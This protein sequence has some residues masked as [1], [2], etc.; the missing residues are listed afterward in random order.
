M[1][2]MTEDELRA[3]TD[4]EIADATSFSEALATKR[5][6]NLSYFMGLAEGDLAPPEIE[7]RSSVVD[8]T[9]RNT[10]LGMEGPLIKTFC[11]TENVVEFS[12]TTEDDEEKAKQVT[13]YLNYLLRKKN[14]GYSIVTTWIRDALL[15]KYGFVK[16][17]W[18]DSPVETKEEYRGQTD[19]QLTI[20][21]DDDEIEVIN[22][23]S[24]ED[25]EAAEDK[26]KQLQQMEAQ[27]QQMFEQAQQAIQQN[28]SAAQ[29][30]GQQ[31]V[32]ARQQYEAFVAQPIPLLYDITVRRKKE[33]GRLCVENVPPEEMLVPRNAKSL[34]SVR[35][36]G[37]KVRRT[38]NQLKAAKYDNVKD[39][40][41]GA[42]GHD[43]DTDEAAHRHY[44]NGA[45]PNERN[46]VEPVDQGA[47]EVWITVCYVMCDYDGNGID[48]WRQV[49]RCGKTILRNVEVDDHEFVGWCPIPMP[50]QMIGLC[51]ADLAMP[52]QKAKTFLKRGLHD[53]VH[54]Q[55]NGRNYALEG[56]VN[57]DDLLD[58][59][60]GGVVR[61][62]ELGAVGRLDQ[63][64][65]D[66]TGAMTLLEAEE[67]DG[68]EST[69]WT[70]QSQ[71]GNGQPLDQT[72]TAAN[73][74]TNR[75]DARTE[76][77]AR[78]FAETGYP[79][80]FY[81]M[82]K[83]VCQHQKKADRVKLNGKWQDV[84]PREWTNKF[85]MTINVGLGTG[86]KDQQVQH[87]MALK[88]AQAEGLAIGICKP[89]H[90]YNADMKLAEALGFK[91]GDQFFH[92]PEA[93]PD[94]GAP[95]PP[96]PPPNPDVVKAQMADQ[97]HQREMQF[98]QQQAEADR[99]HA[100]QLEQYKG[101]M[102][103]EVDRNRQEVEAQQKLAELQQ[104]AE[105][106]RI[107]EQFAHERELG[108]ME[109]ERD[110]LAL[111]QYRID[112][113]E[114]TKIVVAQIA[115]KQAGDAALVAAEA[116]ANAGAANGDD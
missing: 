67:L 97:A 50:H 96:P 62:K 24:Y 73:I 64:V 42:G 20:L 65:G 108:K 75:A 107:K 109:L 90:V 34:G 61:I 85:D 12:E 68:E 4:A 9:V 66:L 58:S 80:L 79:D 63:G 41:A 27:L 1:T 46:A 92:D 15:Q 33:G 49:V 36:V 30:A 83:L 39:I 104:Q 99:N 57:L 2:R 51:P 17:W 112:K 59:R 7:G 40:S 26:S 116:T 44:L 48:T 86:N 56:K 43:D 87:L 115:A 111:E 60:P 88:Q 70:R 37:H 100:A 45:S 76:V 78:V 82:L 98:K 23:K 69:G 71:G 110:K 113:Q 72:A 8:T 14:P 55:V 77:V 16:V 102:Q 5:K 19:V 54:L 89:V 38:I 81:K 13:D 94:P 74:V 31:F 47:R 29:Q 21:L 52:H 95:P 32:E 11:G 103:M 10:L 106:E 35:F 101:Q 114:E 84:D 18:D 6:K 105:L 93:P 53:N 28:P 3:L 22:Q 91:S 25:Q